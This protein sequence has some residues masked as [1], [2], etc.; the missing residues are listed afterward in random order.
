MLSN[1]ATHE[2]LPGP[3]VRWRS[4]HRRW[5][6]EGTPEGNGIRPRLSGRA[7][8]ARHRIGPHGWS[9][10]P[11]GSSAATHR[12]CPSRRRQNALHGRAAFAQQEL[13]VRCPS[14]PCGVPQRQGRG[15]RMRRRVRPRNVASARFGCQNALCTRRRHLTPPSSGRSKGRFALFGPPLMSNVRP[16]LRDRGPPMQEHR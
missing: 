13:T 15:Q 2:P 9:Y 1:A 7:A 14:R 4:A 10:R 6:A 5:S 3:P 8:R 11:S 12:R 16:L